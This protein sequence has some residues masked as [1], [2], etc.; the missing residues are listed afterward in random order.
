MQ[1]RRPKKIT[2]MRGRRSAG[3]GFSAGH[4]AS[5]Q[6]G[7]KGMAGSKKHHYIKV[8][9]EN[10]RYFGKWGFRRPQ[11]L[12]EG[13]VVVNI[14]D[15]DEAL[16]RLVE[17]GGATKKGH[18]YTVDVSAIGID[19]ILGS[20]K[21]TQKIDLVGVRAISARAREKVLEKGGSIDLEKE[22]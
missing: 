11:K 5:G 14:G 18:T 10:P 9:Q 15:I 17:R 7:G 21:V 8:M 22:A 20:G 16:E 19:K 6:R 13:L 1:K 4:R 12:I 3:Y 2:K